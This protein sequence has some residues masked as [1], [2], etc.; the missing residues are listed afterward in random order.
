MNSRSKGRRGQQQARDLLTERDFSVAELNSGTAVEDFLAVDTN[1]ITWSVEVKNTKA[2]TT[3][4]R[5]QAM[6]QAQQRRL[7]WMLVSHIAG[8]SSWLIQRQGMNPVVWGKE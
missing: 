3:E 1:G 6:K 2:I 8:T 7:P 4:H 5:Q